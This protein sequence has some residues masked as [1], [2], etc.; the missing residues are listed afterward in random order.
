MRSQFACSADLSMLWHSR[1]RA[2]R[3]ISLRRMSKSQMLFGGHLFLAYC[4][5]GRSACI[6]AS[7]PST[8]KQASQWLCHLTS[9]C[10]QWLQDSQTFTALQTSWT[11]GHQSKEPSPDL[12]LRLKF[13]FLFPFEVPCEVWVSWIKFHLST[14]LSAQCPRRTWRS[15]IAIVC[16]YYLVWHDRGSSFLDQLDFQGTHHW[17]NLA[18]LGA[19]L[20]ASLWPLNSL[21]IWKSHFHHELICSSQWS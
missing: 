13:S 2:S 1:C 15:W 10:L 4:N 18:K 14:Q 11:V 12:Q 6:E 8:A 9:L 3:R 21:I 5:L 7:R 16:L 19:P 20:F 17:A